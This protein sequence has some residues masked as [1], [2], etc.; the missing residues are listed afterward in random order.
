MESLKTETQGLQAEKDAKEE[1]LAELQKDVNETKSK[2]K[3]LSLYTCIF[4]ISLQI[5]PFY[6]LSRLINFPCPNKYPLCC[7]VHILPILEF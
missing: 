3:T 7:V 1:T 5:T 6:V 2:V 4:Y